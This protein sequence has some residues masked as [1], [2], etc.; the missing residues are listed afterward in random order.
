[1][2]TAVV[3]GAA[4]GLGRAMAERLLADGFDVWAVDSDAAELDRMAA[5]T[6]V[7]PVALDVT[8]EQAVADL[9]AQLPACDALINN[10]GIWRFTKLAD[11]PARRGPPRARGERRRPP[12]VDAA[13]P[14]AAAAALGLDRQ[15]LLDHRDDV[16]DRHRRLPAVQGGAG[17]H[18]QDGGRR[19]RPAGR[20]VQRRRPGHRPD[21]GNAGPLRRRRDPRPPRP[22][23]AG[24]ALR[25]PRGRR[26]RG[27]V[28][29]LGRRALRHRPGHLR[30]RRLHRGGRRLLPPRPR[31]RE[32]AEPCASLPSPVVTGSISRPSPAC[33][34]RSAASGDGRSRT[35]SN[36]PRRPGCGPNTA[37]RSTPCCA[38][39]CPG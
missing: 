4:R 15:H 18:D 1:M 8:D 10:A 20:A 31:R 2:P 28:L 17:G 11:T 34:T 13:L 35:P 26:R 22:H 24:A 32:R 14:A 7:H 25:P 36:R 12:A 30:R 6:G 3:T 38:T 19:V 27:V 21:R 33:S 29:L 23:P 16:A 9:V 39:T 37:A 5:D